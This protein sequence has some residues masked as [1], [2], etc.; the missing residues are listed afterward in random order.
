MESDCREQQSIDEDCNDG[1]AMPKLIRHVLNGAIVS[2]GQHMGQVYF[3]TPRGEALP[4]IILPCDNQ[5]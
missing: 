1:D 3:P 4:K 5:M 2:D